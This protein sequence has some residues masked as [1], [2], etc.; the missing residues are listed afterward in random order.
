MDGSISA[1]SRARSNIV[2]AVKFYES[3]LMIEEIRVIGHSIIQRDAKFENC[4]KGN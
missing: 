1:P 3:N 4:E 2:S